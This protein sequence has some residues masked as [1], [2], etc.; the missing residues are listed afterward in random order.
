VIGL[1]APFTAHGIVDGEFIE[2]GTILAKE[3]INAGG[4]IV[5]GDKHYM[6][7]YQKLDSQL[8]EQR[9]IANTQ[10]LLGVRG[11]VA[12]IEEGVG[13]RVSAAATDSAHVLHWVAVVGARLAPGGSAPASVYRVAPQDKDMVP[14]LLG[15]ALAS[16]CSRPALL[17]D[18]TLYGQDVRDLARTVAREKQVDLSS[19]QVL[20]SADPNY[21]SQAKT[22]Q[23]A[24]AD[25]VLIW[26]FG[27]QVA[28]AA[29]A[30]RRSGFAVAGKPI[31][32]YASAEA[33]QAGLRAMLGDHPDQVDGITLVSFRANPDPQR[34]SEFEKKYFK[35][36]GAFVGGFKDREG[37]QIRIIDDWDMNAYDAVYATKRAIELA[38][39]VDP[40]DGKILA[41]VGEVQ[42]TAAN[43]R[44]VDF[45]NGNHEGFG[46][47][48]IFLATFSDMKVMPVSP[49]YMD[50]Q[51]IDQLV[52]NVPN[53]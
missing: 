53:H 32:I 14:L 3:E 25:C 8:S 12:I 11:L 2:R 20:P 46:S 26:G 37:R 48:D 15:R 35:R 36:F 34:F 18:P 42:M 31:P 13:F 38:G 30:I 47:S 43:G 17:T 1:N 16:G 40:T 6:V 33:E 39:T 45:R 52:S 5:V 7:D 29:L 50:V 28:K 27:D 19:D 4:G 9:S 41:R 23:T 22:I 21:D 24:K 10:Q 44:Q 51:S 49:E